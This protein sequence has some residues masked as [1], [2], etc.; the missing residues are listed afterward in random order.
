VR[1]ALVDSTRTVRAHDLLLSSF[2]IRD[3]GGVLGVVRRG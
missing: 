3:G 1:I 2:E